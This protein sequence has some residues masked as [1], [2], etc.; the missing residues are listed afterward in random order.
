[1][2]VKPKE[3]WLHA[4]FPLSENSIILTISYH[5]ITNIA[6][7][8][9]YYS[10]KH[11]TNYSVTLWS[12]LGTITVQIGKVT[13]KVCTNAYFDILPAAAGNDDSMIITCQ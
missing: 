4:L 2:S 9:F 12:S 6:A 3:Y 11:F 8:L 1:M 13:F 7:Y 10:L 5:N